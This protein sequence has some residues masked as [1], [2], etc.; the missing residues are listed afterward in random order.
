MKFW[1]YIK[2]LLVM[3]TIPFTC[4]VFLGCI[5]SGTT[6]ENTRKVH[7]NENYGT[8]HIFSRMDF[9]KNV[10]GKAWEKKTL[11]RVGPDGSVV[12][13]YMHGDIVN[14][15]GNGETAY[16]YFSQDSVILFYKGT[17]GRPCHDAFLYF[18][19][20]NDSLL[21]WT[22]EFRRS[23][24]GADTLHS[25]IPVFLKI[26]TFDASTDNFMAEERKGQQNAVAYELSSFR[27]IDEPTFNHIRRTYGAYT[28]EQVYEIHMKELNDRRM[29]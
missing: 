28:S 24:A 14:V 7:R 6:S 22:H 2:S 16:Y 17:S 15:V 1:R 18:W 27:R 5:C 12:E 25:T 13:Q 19:E 8:T 29:K 10:A 3:I 23:I 4:Y 9:E 21:T 11:Q 20:E 26:I